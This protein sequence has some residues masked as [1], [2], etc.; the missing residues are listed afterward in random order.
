[1]L[2]RDAAVAAVPSEGAWE[3][4]RTGSEA[5]IATEQN[6]DGQGRR[7]TRYSRE[8]RSAER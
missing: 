7:G 3:N 4:P 5:A 6:R 1:M 2:A 8:L